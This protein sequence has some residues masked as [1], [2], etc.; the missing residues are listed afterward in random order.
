MKHMIETFEDAEYIVTP[1]G[2]CATMFHEYPHVFKDDQ[3]GLN[4]HKSC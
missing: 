4:V 3:S 1:S 2:S